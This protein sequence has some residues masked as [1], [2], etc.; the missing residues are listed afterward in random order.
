MFHQYFVQIRRDIR[1]DLFEGQPDQQTVRHTDHFRFALG[2]L[3]L[4][5]R[6]RIGGLFRHIQIYDPRIRSFGPVYS[7]GTEP[8]DQTKHAR[9]RIRVLHDP[10]GTVGI[11]D[12]CR[13]G[14]IIRAVVGT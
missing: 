2:E 7:R 3:M 6:R 4:V 1:R 10:V 14:H 12:A 13:A 9:G 5:S 8:H 11:P